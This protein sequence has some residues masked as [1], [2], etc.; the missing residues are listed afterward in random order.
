[1]LKLSQPNISEEA[2]AAVA[3]VCA[4]VNSCMARRGEAFESELAA[5]LRCREVV[6]VSSGTA[7]LHLALMALDVGPGDAVIVPDFTFP[8]TANVIALMGAAPRDR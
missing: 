1:M 2:I 7:A 3:D 5:Y 6:L 8:A 4:P